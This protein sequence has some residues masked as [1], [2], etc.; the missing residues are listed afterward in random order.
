MHHNRPCHRFPGLVSSARSASRRCS[1]S[2]VSSLVASSTEHA[3]NAMF[4]GAH[5]GKD[6]PRRD[7]GPEAQAHTPLKPFRAACPSWVR[8]S[9]N[10]VRWRSEKVQQA[11]LRPPWSAARRRDALRTP[12]ASSRPR[13]PAPDRFSAEGDSASRSRR[14]ADGNRCGWMSPDGPV[15][16]QECQHRRCPRVVRRTGI[17][18]AAKIAA[19]KDRVN[20][21]LPI[22][23]V[24]E[25]ASC[26]G[27][28]INEKT[29]SC[30]ALCPVVNG[31]CCIRRTSESA[32]PAFAVGRHGAISENHAWKRRGCQMLNRNKRMRP[33]AFW[34]N[35]WVPVVV[36]GAS[37]WP[38]FR[39]AMP[40]PADR[41]GGRCSCSAA[42]PRSSRK[43]IPCPVVE[44]LNG[45]GVLPGP[46]R[47]RGKAPTT[48]SKTPAPPRTSRRSRRSTNFIDELGVES[49]QR[50]SHRLTSTRATTNRIPRASTCSTAA[51]PQENIFVKY[52]PFGSPDWSSIVADVVFRAIVPA[53]S[54]SGNL[55]P[56]NGSANVGFLTAELAASGVSS[57]DDI[58]VVAF[59][60]REEEAFGLDNPAPLAGISRPWNYFMS[61]DTARNEGL[62]S[63]PGN[64]NTPADTEPGDQR[65]EW[66]AHYIGFNM[67]VQAVEAGRNHR[68]RTR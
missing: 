25:R 13:T 63:K 36:D 59:S 27:D 17:H 12:A 53:A 5:R 19:D 39:R 9:S 42:G 4:V 44:E 1:P 26:F 2:V 18:V 29:Y 66:R 34:A 41:G 7:V 31:P 68:S 22:A 52:T 64:G 65:P 54:R 24:S 10:S 61:A 11:K 28:T 40:R 33:A 30:Q 60:R 6:L 14:L 57:A 21:V 45:L 16:P 48:C 49:L 8:K 38:N 32:N 50:C 58:P 37:D 15:D 23:A 20:A 62:S 46:V 55:R 47:G 43:A 56:I 67:W 35:S 51:I 3:R